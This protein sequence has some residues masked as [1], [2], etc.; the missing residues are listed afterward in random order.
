[1][2]NY[3]GGTINGGV[4]WEYF[5]KFKDITEKY[6]PFKGEGENMATQ[7]VTATNK[8]VYKW[9]NDGD[10]YDNHYGM[11][12]WCNDL[13]SYANW[14]HQYAKGTS[15]ILNQIRDCK[16]HAEY[17]QILKTL[18]DLTNTEEYLKEYEKQ[19][20]CES[21]YDCEGPYEFTLDDDEIDDEYW[22]D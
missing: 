18:T 11:I 14:L 7:I 8:L 16:T 6:L 20:K 21:I 15:E 5:D 3:N 4:D 12:G 13:S 9:Y 17:E 1:M 19:K 22:E 2:S 10:V